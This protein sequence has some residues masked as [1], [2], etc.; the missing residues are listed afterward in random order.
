MVSGQ[1]MSSSNNNE[2]IPELCYQECV[3]DHGSPELLI[4]RFTGKPAKVEPGHPRKDLK[5][6]FWTHNFYYPS[7]E[8]HK[9]AAEQLAPVCKK[10]I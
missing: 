5:C 7:T 10:Y 9:K 6:P 2:W 3:S 8:M 4:S 1:D